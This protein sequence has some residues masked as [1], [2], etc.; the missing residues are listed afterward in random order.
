M[1]EDDQRLSLTLNLRQLR[2]IDEAMDVVE[3]HLERLLTVDEECDEDD[4]ELPGRPTLRSFQPMPETRLQGDAER[5][6]RET[7]M[8][9]VL[10]PQLDAEGM[11]VA[12]AG[13][14]L[15][16]LDQLRPRLERLQR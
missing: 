13:E 7:L 10:N 1:N 4:E 2:A 6:C 12:D 9:L 14:M 5:F 16:A 15:R 8:R 3:S 11:G